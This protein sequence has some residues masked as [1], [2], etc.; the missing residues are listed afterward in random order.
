MRLCPKI[1]P[2]TGSTLN[3]TLTLTNA[4]PALALFCCKTCPLV[5]FK[6]LH[7][8]N[9]ADILAINRPTWTSHRTVHDCCKVYFTVLIRPIQKQPFSSFKVLK[10]ISLGIFQGIIGRD[11]NVSNTKQLGVD[12]FPGLPRG[13]LK[14][15]DDGGKV[16][17]PDGEVGGSIPGGEIIST[18]STWRKHVRWSSISCVPKIYNVWFF[19]VKLQNV[20]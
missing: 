16:P 12:I 4:M 9:E 8:I 1:S 2:D 11:L 19:F 17:D 20:V 7:G 10:S 13:D 18:E 5:L 6:N 14:L 15:S 3:N